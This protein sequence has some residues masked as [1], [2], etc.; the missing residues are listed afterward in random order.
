MI[1]L[2]TPLA[3]FTAI[4]KTTAPRLKKLGLTT[5]EDLLFYF[6][7]K[8]L[9]FSMVTPIARLEPNME[10][11]IAGQVEHIENRRSWRKRMMVTQAMIA[12]QTGS[13]A[14]VWFGQPYIGKMLAVGNEVM[15]SG[16]TQ[17]GEY[18]LQF[19]SPIFEKKSD[20]PAHTG[21]LIPLYP[22]TSHITQKQIRTLMKYAMRL[23][24]HIP[25]FLPV[26]I[27]KT[28]QLVSE[29]F[30]LEQI[31]FPTDH[32]HVA[33]AENRLK[34]DELFLLQA[35][36]AKRKHETLGLQAPPVPFHETE[37]KTFVQSLP[38]TLTDAQ[39]KAAWQI[40]KNMEKPHPMNRLLEGDVGSGKT[41]VAAIALLNTALSGFQGAIMAPT[42][43]LASQ[44]F[45][46]ISKLLA[47][48]GIQPALL[49]GSWA[50]LSNDDISKK[51]LL[52]KIQSG[53]IHIVVGTH[54]L[55]QDRV[56][57][58]NLALAVIDEQHRFGVKQR[59]KLKTK[60]GT[61]ENPHLLSMTATPIPRT[62]YLTLYGDLDLSVLDEQPKGRQ[63]I[64]TTIIA[65][66]ERSATLSMIDQEI[67]KGRQ[68]FVLCPLIDES[69]KLGLKAAQAE[70][71]KLRT[72]TFAH[73][74]IGLLHG[75]LSGAEKERVMGEFANGDIDLLVSTPVVEV[76][77]DIPNASVMMVENAERFGLSQ[78]W[79]LRGRVGR[80]LHQSYC[81]L[82]PE[83]DSK[84][85]IDRLR[86]VLISKNGFELAEKDLELRGPGE[87][88]GTAQSGFAND[89]RIATLLDWKIIEQAKHSAETFLNQ[90]ADLSKYP[91]LKEKI[92]QTEKKLHFE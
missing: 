65:P 70:Y 77:V 61:D 7:R 28:E 57:F 43:I 80:G 85:S 21:R 25:D 73:R 12:D 59:Q 78:I 40:I 67:E 3:E 90:N 47:L 41:I 10:T 36:H 86:A 51:D 30:A 37:I 15:I 19:V 53:E 83:S 31:H 49:T 13:V 45:E 46:T 52:K 74:R 6:P 1:T 88:Y 75:R 69:D 2:Q 42:E 32:A 54:A 87:V 27:R 84:T 91:L 23:A 62:L 56:R 8:Y 35:I 24:I 29:A 79:Q 18:G 89:L 39:R 64:Q 58:K 26:E 14:A 71:D 60:S 66:H 50:K 4:G 5:I 34:F 22:L 63:E 68:V 81:F 82:F 16:K 92:E 48:A 38:F 20:D 33:R 72:T 55:I 9:D 11:T 44:H 76:G 17:L